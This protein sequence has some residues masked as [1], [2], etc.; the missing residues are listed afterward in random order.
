MAPPGI[1]YV[2]M[3]PR[4]GLS[5]D[6]FHEWYNNEHGPTRLRLPKIFSN[7]LRY[8][9]TDSLEPTFLAAYDVTSMSQLETETYLTLRANRSP[10][11]ADTI[12]QVQVKRYFYDLVH[13]KESTHFTPLEKLSDQEAE[14]IQTT[15]VDIQLKDV[16]G[17]GEHYQKWLIEEHI[18]MIAKV[19]GWLRSR[20]FKTSYLEPQG[21][22]TYFALHDYTKE[23]GQGGKEHK[24]SMDTPWRT[25]IFDKYVAS[26]GR[27]T[28]SLFYVFG[29]APRELSSLSR[30]ASTAAFTSSDSKTTT[31]PGSS[32][33]IDS[34]ITTPDSLTIPYR[35]E[36]NP[37]HHAPTVAFSNSLLTSLNM[38]DPFVEVLKRERPDLRIVRYDTR[39]R[40]AMPQPPVAATLENLADDLLAV[41]DALRITRLHALIGVSMGG[42]TT[43]NFAIKYPERLEKFIACDFNATSSAANTQ[44]WKDR[45]ALAEEDNGKGIGKLAEQT[46]SRWFHPATMEKKPDTAKW[47]TE[48]VAA[49]NVEGF[50]YSCTALWEYDLKPKMGGCNVPGLLV[51]GEGDAKGAL[52]KAMDG[53]KDKLGGNGA[54]LKTVPQAGHL[55]MCEDPQAFWDAIR[56]FV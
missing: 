40:H 49:N 54:Q 32:A 21:K 5:L 52:V 12:G 2:T 53:F 22:T 1:L 42:A 50:K 27:R 23:N 11:E 34:Y 25:E 19:P 37:D 7:G 51:V 16:E 24:A 39:G 45:T 20:V 47:M 30:L 33:V 26:K 31:T 55:P 44:S 41:L 8:K 14:G 13:T 10:R 48:M 6:Q 29:P 4:P 18:E 43:L 38:W 17:A 9:A 36:G 35:L 15:A 3:Q 46:V 56:D 28:Y